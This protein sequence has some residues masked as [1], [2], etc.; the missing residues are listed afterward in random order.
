MIVDIAKS[1]MADSVIGLLFL[2]LQ[3]IC[4]ERESFFFFFSH[5]SIIGCLL[6][7]HGWHFEII[8]DKYKWAW[9]GYFLKG[10]WCHYDYV[11]MIVSVYLFE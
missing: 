2:N 10:Q 3:T 4:L 5:S 8:Q 11:S 9:K 6:Q 1:N 7:N